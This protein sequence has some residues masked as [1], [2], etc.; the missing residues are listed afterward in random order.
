[1]DN[2]ST[3]PIT[4]IKKS[5]KPRCHNCNNKLKLVGTWTCECLNKYCTKCRSPETHD[6]KFDYAGKQK[7][8]LRN[9]LVEIKHEKIIKI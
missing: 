1:M 9:Q 2:T 5:S 4:P 7:D 6:C 3:K 8:L